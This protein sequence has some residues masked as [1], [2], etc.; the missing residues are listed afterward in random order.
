MDSEIWALLGV[1]VGG[2]LSFV[3]SYLADRASWQRNQ[4]VR[5]DERRLSAYAEYGFAVKDIVNLSCRLAASRGLHNDA[6]PLPVSEVSLTTLAEAEAHRSANS[7]TFR[8]LTDPETS[9]AA[10][11]MTQCAW[12]LSWLARGLIQ[13][14]Q[15][16]WQKKYREYEL[17]RDVYMTCARK[18]LHIIGEHVPTHMP[19]LSSFDLGNDDSP[20]LTLPSNPASLPPA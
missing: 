20:R 14:D 1:I 9:A 3:A 12:N 13:G 15:G 19:R 2:L 6:E 11:H 5:W 10:I 4:M 7:E 16:L 18:S 8:L 17:A